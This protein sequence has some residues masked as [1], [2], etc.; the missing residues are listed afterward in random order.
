MSEQASMFPWVADYPLKRK[1][2]PPDC[3]ICGSK[4]RMWSGKRPGWADHHT[5][6]DAEVYCTNEHC[7]AHEGVHARRPDKR[8]AEESAAMAW[9]N[10]SLGWKLGA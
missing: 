2:K 8:W 9:V 10:W 7:P 4:A 5:E 1:P 6:F 3:P